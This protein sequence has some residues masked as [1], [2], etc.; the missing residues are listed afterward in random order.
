MAT[1]SLKISVVDKN[2]VKTM[3]FE[4]SIMVYDACRLIKDKIT[5]ANVGQR[6]PSRPIHCYLLLFHS[7]KDYGLFLTDEDP[8]KGV[9]LE[10]GRSLEY[11]LLRNG[12][13]IELGSELAQ[14]WMRSTDECIAL[15]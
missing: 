5:E 12:V 14:P 4:P 2:V 8:K 11:Y 1:L 6:K 13:S 10:P 3:Q 7:A 9:W 15:H